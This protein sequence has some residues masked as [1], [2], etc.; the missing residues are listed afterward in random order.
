MLSGLATGVEFSL[1]GWPLL[2][3]EFHA[4][5]FRSRPRLMEWTHPPFNGVT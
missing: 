5:H 3:I 4:V 2:G 1:E